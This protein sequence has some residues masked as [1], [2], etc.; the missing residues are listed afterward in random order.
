ML[1]SVY[2]NLTE[3]ELASTFGRE[4]ADAVVTVEPGS[5]QGPIRS[6]YGLHLVKVTRRQDSRIPSWTEVRSS[7]V[8]DME[9]EAVNAAKEQLYQEIAQIYHVV[10]DAEV[11]RLLESTAG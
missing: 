9:Y 7:V 4:F 10:T 1:R 6:G 3:A 2:D 5:W 8:R 11:A